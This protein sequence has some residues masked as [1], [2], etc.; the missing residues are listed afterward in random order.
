ML[1]TECGR[2]HGCGSCSTGRVVEAS[3]LPCGEDA[4]VTLYQ[5]IV[6]QVF[7]EDA[8]QGATHA[9]LSVDESSLPPHSNIELQRGRSQAQAS[10]PPPDSASLRSMGDGRSLGGDP[11]A[12]TNNCQPRQNNPIYSDLSVEARQPQRSLHCGGQ[13][14]SATSPPSD[15]D[16]R[17]MLPC[18]TD[19]PHETRRCEHLHPTSDQSD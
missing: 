4:I 19:G 5:K 10:I 18:R 7:P 14:I 1:N 9:D 8:P 3:T 6:L 15:L 16:R 13:Y 2:G 17:N 12:S 11:G